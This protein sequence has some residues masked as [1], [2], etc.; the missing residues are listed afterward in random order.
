MALMADNV[1]YDQAVDAINTTVS[2]MKNL[3]GVAPE[4][5]LTAMAVLAQTN[6]TLAL[7]REQRIAN[8]ISLLN[9]KAFNKRSA[10]RLLEHVADQV[11]MEIHG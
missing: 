2:S 8:L 7:A 6:A 11:G 4:D 5:K 10:Q 9:T 3:S 1:A